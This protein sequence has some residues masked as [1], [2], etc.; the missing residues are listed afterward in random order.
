MTQP[1]P[2]QC[3]PAAVGRVRVSHGVLQ[4][5]TSESLPRPAT[6]FPHYCQRNITRAYIAPP[7]LHCFILIFARRAIETKSLKHFYPKHREIATIQCCSRVIEVR[8]PEATAFTMRSNSASP[9]PHFNALAL[10]PS[11]DIQLSSPSAH[12]LSTIRRRAVR[13]QWTVSSPI[14]SPPVDRAAS[15]VVEE[16]GTSATVEELAWRMQC[17]CIAMA[18]APRARAAGRAAAC[19]ESQLPGRAV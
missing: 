1:G 3:P 7:P 15:A 11:T 19:S 8:N 18:S 13:D 5:V 14:T 6:M 9:R 12:S 2:G 4:S 17:A 10:R 16:P